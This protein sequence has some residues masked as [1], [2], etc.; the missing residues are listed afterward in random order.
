[1]G[2]SGRRDETLARIVTVSAG[3]S[4]EA[5]TLNPEETTALVRL[6]AYRNCGIL[7]TLFL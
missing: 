3:F 7:S 2:S 5:K 6:Y 4:N 1:M